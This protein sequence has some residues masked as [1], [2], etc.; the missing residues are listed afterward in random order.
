MDNNQEISLQEEQNKNDTD[1]STT[2]DSINK[3][4]LVDQDAQ[5]YNVIKSNAKL[6]MAEFAKLQMQNMIDNSQRLNRLQSNLMSNLITETDSEL[7]IKGI[8]VLR[9]CQETNIN[10]MNKV[11]NDSSENSI[12]YNDNRQVNNN[13]TTN[14][15][16]IE[17]SNQ[18]KEKLRNISN[19]IMEVLKL[20]E[21]NN[22]DSQTQ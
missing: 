8:D 14:N 6:F 22:N 19:Q 17:L 15:T 20:E 18:S 3:N 21:N 9:K 11:I 13:T 4:E 7:V 10:L 12:V 16:T 5:V 1:L 2:I